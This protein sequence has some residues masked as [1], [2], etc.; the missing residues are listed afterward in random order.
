MLVGC[1][2]TEPTVRVVTQTV[3]VPIAMPCKQ[4]APTPPDYCFNKLNDS[5][6]IYDKTKCL[7]SDRALSLGYEIELLAKFNACK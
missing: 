7:L 3:N 4:E 2:T 1:A 6:D 5:A